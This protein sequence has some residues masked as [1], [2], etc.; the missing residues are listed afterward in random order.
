VEAA[1]LADAFKA[2]GHPNFA[3]VVSVGALAGLTTVVLILLLGQSR[4]FFAMSRDGLLPDWLAQ[5]HP[6]FGTPYR[7]R[8]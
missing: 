3:T 2:A 1:P 7:R 6:R 4:V 5:I 8:S